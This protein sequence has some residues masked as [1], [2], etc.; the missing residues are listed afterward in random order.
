LGYV[1]RFEI[2]RIGAIIIYAKALFLCFQVILK[3]QAGNVVR[4]L[5]FRV[6]SY[7]SF[8]TAVDFYR[9]LNE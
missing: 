4:L 3:Q 2:S 9:I 1:I 5:S 8:L 6:I 7:M